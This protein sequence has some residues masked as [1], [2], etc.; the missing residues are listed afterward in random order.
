M[1]ELLIN[2]HALYI[3]KLEQR[4]QGLWEW[5]QM[6]KK[7]QVIHTLLDQ[8]KNEQTKIKKKILSK[9]D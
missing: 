8:S 4:D 1:S 6:K 3:F 2:I 7:N 9:F 5:F